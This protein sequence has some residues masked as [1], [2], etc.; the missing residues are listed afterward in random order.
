MGAYR[1]RRPGDALVAGKASGAAQLLCQDP[2]SPCKDAAIRVPTD[3][4]TL[5][6]RVGLAGRGRGPGISDP[7]R[8]TARRVR[9]RYVLAGGRTF[10]PR[11]PGVLTVVTTDVPS[12][13]FWEGTPSHLTG[14]LEYELA[15]DLA[16]RFG[17]KSVRVMHRAFPPDRQ[18]AAR[19][20]RPRSR[21]DHADGPAFE[22]SC[23]SRPR[24]WTRRRRWWCRT[25]PSVPDLET[26]SGPPLGRR[27]R[28]D[29]HR[30]HQQRDRAEPPGADLRQHARRCWPRSK[31]DKIDA[32][33]LDLPLAVVDGRALGRA[34]GGGGAAA[35]LGDDRGGDAQGLEQRAGRRFGDARRSPTTAR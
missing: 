20:R 10:T 15:R 16:D 24:T 25:A 29:V 13:G 26:R 7:R 19:R 6:R 28:D 33:L 4:C 22:V 31:P 23:R 34:A 27:P 18:R 2:G 14:G 9:C 30:N 8:R 5:R 3:S 1:N 12:P 11:T 35:R 32:V 17:L 21:P